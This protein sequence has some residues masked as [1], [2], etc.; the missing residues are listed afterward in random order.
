[1]NNI[2]TFNR[3]AAYIF[4]ELYQSFPIPKDIPLNPAPDE[5]FKDIKDDNNTAVEAH[6]RIMVFQE[7]A[8]WLIEA[9]YI[10]GNVEAT[11]QLH[12]AVLSRKGLEALKSI[13]KA[14]LPSRKKPLGEQM[15]VFIKDGS[16][17]LLSKAV[18][19]ALSNGLTLAMSAIS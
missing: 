19:Q 9:D 5:I 7:T 15:R 4:A 10:W 3:S 8:K 2:E 6:N 13:P 11:S 17:K 14:L 18:D 1:M 12:N 16:Y